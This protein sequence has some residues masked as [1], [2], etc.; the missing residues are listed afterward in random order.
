MG[1]YYT[2]GWETRGEGQHVGGLKLLY[3]R[4]SEAPNQSTATM[5]LGVCNQC[6]PVSPPLILKVSQL[7]FRLPPPSSPPPTVPRSNSRCPALSPPLPGC[8]G[9]PRHP[10]LPLAPPPPGTHQAAVRA[11]PDL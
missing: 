1:V 2:Y 5:H 10:A 3:S 8:S 6:K 11:A 4:L 9:N 7:C